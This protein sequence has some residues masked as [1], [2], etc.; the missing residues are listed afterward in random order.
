MVLHDNIVTP[1][2]RANG[3]GGIDP[4]RFQEAIE[5]LA[6]T[7]KFKSKPKLDDVFDAS[8]LPAAS[9]RKVN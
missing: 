5:Q 1:E 8:F 4:A 3:Y 7:V 2:V 6:L 9:E